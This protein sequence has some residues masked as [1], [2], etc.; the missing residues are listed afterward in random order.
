M[1][2]PLRDRLGGAADEVTMAAY[3][4]QQGGRPVGSGQT[5]LLASHT[6]QPAAVPAGPNVLFQGSGSKG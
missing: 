5:A 6:R 3:L 2:S 1:G 4:L